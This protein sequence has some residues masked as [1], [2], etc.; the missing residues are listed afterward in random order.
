M[1]GHTARQFARAL[2]ATSAI[3]AGCSQSQ[4]PTAPTASPPN[5]SVGAITS[6]V[7]AD[8]VLGTIVV[9]KAGNTSGSFT[10][11]GGN[12]SGGTL[13]PGECATVATD[14]TTVSG[15]GSTITVNET[16]TASVQTIAA[17]RNDNGTT[18][19]FSFTNNTPLFLN[20]F[21]GYLITF[22]NT[23]VSQ[24]CTFT[25]GYWKTHG[26]TKK[27][28]PNAW[29]VASLVIGGQ[30]YTKLE[31]IAIMEAPTAGNGVMSLVQQLIAA[32]LNILNG[33][34]GATIAAAIAAADA[35]IDAA[36]GKIVPPYTSVFL[37]PSVTSALN[38]QLT[39]YNEG[40]TGPGHCG[41]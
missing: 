12:G 37:D 9:C 33:A 27:N 36:G 24:G 25:Q 40:T 13:A 34:S 10:V 17:R 4:S 30:T 39:A 26:G 29:P 15:V 31:L 16:T 6:T 2:L 20:N 35:M 14:F 41:G 22:T 1:S 3:L 5:L 32:K 7:P 38:D 8:A 21:H 19:S 28:I 23:N 11:T 18:S